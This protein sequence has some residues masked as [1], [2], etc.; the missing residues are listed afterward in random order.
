MIPKLPKSRQ[1]Y[2]S[3]PKSSQKFPIIF[4]STQK[5]LK[6]VFFFFSPT[7]LQMNSKKNPLE[8]LMK[9]IESDK[10]GDPVDLDKWVLKT[11]KPDIFKKV[12][13]LMKGVYKIGH[14]KP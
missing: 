12:E 8:K 3:I 13:N 4:K 5:Y 14:L 10:S 7:N 2:T 6:F 11:K 9:S 1:K